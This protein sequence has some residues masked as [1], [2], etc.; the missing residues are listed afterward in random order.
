MH[1]QKY[2]EKKLKEIQALKQKPILKPEEIE[3]VKKEAIFKRCI[4]ILG[5]NPLQDILPLQIKHTPS[6][7]SK[8]QETDLENYKIIL[9]ELPDDLRRTILEFLPLNTN[10]LF[11]DYANRLSKLSVKYSP[12]ISQ[13]LSNLPVT[14]ATVKKL[15][16]SYK[17]IEPVIFSIRNYV[18]RRDSAYFCSDFDFSDRKKHYV[19]FCI[20][21]EKQKLS[22]KE[23]FKEIV[24][25][26]QYTITHYKKMYRKNKQ[27]DLTNYD[28]VEI[29]QHEINM[30]KLFNLL[31][32][33]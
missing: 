23:C 10:T 24:H 18:S 22:I 20:L 2:Y 17:Y 30:I 7:Q 11:N 26:I 33:I 21:G 19:Y 25:N 32:H 15:A 31:L 3:K 12:M 14:F 4:F 13:K 28:L 6:L 9:E 5:T 1:S 29:R 27:K 8:S 16:S